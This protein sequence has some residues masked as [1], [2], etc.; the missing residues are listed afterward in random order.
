MSVEAPAF[1][2]A[3]LTHRWAREHRI[4]VVTS[5]P[6]WKY[7]VALLVPHHAEGETPDPDAFSLW[8]AVWPTDEEAAVVGSYIDYRME[9]YNEGWRQ[10]MRARALDVDSSTNTVTL[11][12][13]ANG[14]TYTRATYSHS[15]F[16]P[17]YNKPQHAPTKDGLIALVMAINTYGDQVRE[18]FAE[19]MARHPGV[20]S[21]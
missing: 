12:K 9:Y 17:L 14:W 21:R 1:T 4:P 10:Q 13:N 3:D 19:W 2:D 18:P 16:Y 11:R 5:T 7:E 8:G 20:W 15:L 6:S